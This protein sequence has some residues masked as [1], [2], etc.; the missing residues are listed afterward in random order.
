MLSY[1][2]EASKSKS[3]ICC[4]T[5]YVTAFP[6]IHPFFWALFDEVDMYIQVT[7]GTNITGVV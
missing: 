4:A 3:I 6:E 7:V 2:F 5:S 1:R